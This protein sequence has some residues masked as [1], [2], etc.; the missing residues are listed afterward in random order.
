MNI[1]LELFPFSE[2]QLFDNSKKLFIMLIIEYLQNS[3]FEKQSYL[4]YFKKSKIYFIFL[5]KYVC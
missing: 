2:C 4:K 3:I 1:F 5:K